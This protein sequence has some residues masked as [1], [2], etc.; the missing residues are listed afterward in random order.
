MQFPVGL[1][2]LIFLI[3]TGLAGKGIAMDYHD[4]RQSGNIQMMKLMGLNTPTYWLSKMVS[5]ILLTAINV[6]LI[7]IAIVVFLSSFKAFSTSSLVGIFF[8]FIMFNLN[9][10]PFFFT[11]AT[12]G[13]S[14]DITSAISG[15]FVWIAPFIHMLMLNTYHGNIPLSIRAPLNFLPVYNFQSFMFEILTN[16]LKNDTACMLVLNFL[17]WSI[18]WIY[19]DL[20]IPSKST[21]ATKSPWFC[22]AFCCRKR[23]EPIEEGNVVLSVRG[24]TKRWGSFTAVNNLNLE[25]ESG[26]IYGLLGFNGAGKSTTVNMITGMISPSEGEVLI[27]GISMS[28]DPLA[29]RKHLGI[30]PQEDIIW[31][32]LTFMDHIEFF[33]SLRGMNMEEINQQMQ[34]YFTKLDVLR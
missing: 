20:V 25:L 14:T 28:R 32:T 23:S 22:F 6:C 3:I 2:I 9:M 24:L 17:F 21:S 30:C 26:Q 4:E 16:D 19:T 27:Q 11:L 31:D 34:P 5:F 10:G 7:G 33:G 15:I 13:I 12:I 29:A 18:I 8:G 1:V